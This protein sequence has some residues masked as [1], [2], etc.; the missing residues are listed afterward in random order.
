MMYRLLVVDDEEII[1]SGILAR[2]E[3]LNIE[4]DE[5]REASTGKEAFE[6][7]ESWRCDIVITDIRMPDMDGL[8]LIESAK[9]FWPDMKFV[10]ISGYT[11]FEYAEK[12][13]EIGVNAYLVKPLSNSALRDVMAKLFT[14]IAEEN[15]V[16]HIVN[17]QK[18]LKDERQ[19]FLLEMEVNSLLSKN[20]HFKISNKVYP[21]L[22]EK[23]P[24]MFQAENYYLIAAIS[25]DVSSFEENRYRREEMELL[26]FSVKNVFNELTCRCEKMIVNNLTKKDQ[27]YAFLWG[28]DVK[29]LRREIERIFVEMRSF[30]KTK[31]DM[32]ISVGVS[33][34]SKNLENMNYQE[35]QDAL[36]QKHLYGRSNIYFYEDISNIHEFNFP[37]S[38]LT[39]LSQYLERKDIGNI[40]TILGEIF[41]EER[42]EKYR[43]P[44][45]RIMWM[46]VLNLVI[47]NIGNDASSG[48]NI[49][50]IADCFSDVENEYK[51]DEL[52]KKYVSLVVE[53]LGDNCVDG[54]DAKNKIKMAVRYIEKHYYEDISV[55]QLAEKY[56]MS[57]NYF[58]TLFKKEMGQS[59]VNYVTNLRI[60]KAKD[61]LK[62]SDKSVGEI[63][64]IIGYEDCNYFFRVFKK[65]VGMTPLQYREIYVKE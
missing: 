17:Q 65:N 45:V 44:Y 50:K 34:V 14:Q 62:K 51:I 23:W 41:S 53:C 3:Y 26:R 13:I 61:F 27:L 22:F 25:V 60:S 4:F 21:T 39:V 52:Q 9:V 19:D 37:M 30:F 47:Q 56:D 55:N 31:M 1:R 18:R 15:N 10:I 24:Q 36:D 7:L 8:A 16:R 38:E 33:T 58:S 35:A 54:N 5:I 2:L 29:L 40:E 32:Y 6:I 20:E 46:H 48:S 42:V 12:A 63:A 59:T 64:E 49:R 28:P 57:S 43:T 11:E